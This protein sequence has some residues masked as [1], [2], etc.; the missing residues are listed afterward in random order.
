MLENFNT[1]DRLRRSTKTR[2]DWWRA[3]KNWFFGHFYTKV[4]FSRKKGSDW[5]GLHLGIR[6]YKCSG[7][8]SRIPHIWV[9]RGTGAIKAQ[10][11]PIGNNLLRLGLCVTPVIFYLQ[12]IYEKVSDC[13]IRYLSNAFL[14]FTISACYRELWHKECG[15]ATLLTTTLLPPFSVFY[16]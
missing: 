4:D 12:R 1:V 8:F 5:G 7:N 16:V 13:S 11:C 15:C 14:I 6:K 2:K 3:K 9:W 10:T